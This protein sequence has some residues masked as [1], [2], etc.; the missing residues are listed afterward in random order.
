[1][2]EAESW[3]PAFPGQRPPFEPGNTVS[4]KH[5][6]RSVVQLRPRAEEI[7]AQLVEAAPVAEAADG[8]QFDIAAGLLAHAERALLILEGSQRLEIEAINA[9]APMDVAERQNLARLSADTRGWL[10]SAMRALDRL[11]MNPTARARLGLDLASARRE[12]SVIDYY[13]AR[14]EEAA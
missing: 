7:R 1:M 9:G 3:T 11:G 14:A 8:A 12:L 13:A 4:V 10:N 6:A 5:G 2:S